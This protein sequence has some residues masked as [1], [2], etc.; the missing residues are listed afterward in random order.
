MVI[1]RLESAERDGNAAK[2]KTQP[3]LRL[4]KK[5]LH[6]YGVGLTVLTVASSDG[7]PRPATKKL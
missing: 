3:E 1:V 6:F 4:C 2:E 7:V 5:N